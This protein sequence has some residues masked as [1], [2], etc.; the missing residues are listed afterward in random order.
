M[1]IE[2]IQKSEAQI[3]QKLLD[4]RQT[5]TG[6]ITEFGLGWLSCL[7]WIFDPNNAEAS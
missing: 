1:K 2:T 7:E 4:M 3:H 6:S 5:A